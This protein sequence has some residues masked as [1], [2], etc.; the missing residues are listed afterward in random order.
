MNRPEDV[1]FKL[2][3]LNKKMSPYNDMTDKILET[4]LER[5]VSDGLVNEEELETQILEYF[6]NNPEQKENSGIRKDYRDLLIEYYF[7][8]S[9]PEEDIES[10]INLAR[11]HE[12]I[13]VLAR[14]VTRENKSSKEIKKYLDDFCRIPAGDVFLPLNETKEIRVKLIDRFISNQLPYIGIAK[15]HINVRDIGKLTDNFYGATSKTGRIGGKAAGII[16]AHKILKP[17]IGEIDEELEK[18]VTIPQSWFFNSE[19]FSDF[20]DYN[21]LH[22]FHSQKYKN[23][24]DLQRDFKIIDKTIMDSEMPPAQRKMIRGFLEKIG[25]DAP[26][27]LR[28]ST[29]LEDNMGY[30]FS[31]KYDSIFISNQ[32]KIKDRVDEFI[33]AFKKVHIS[34]FALDP[35]IYR[36]DHNLLDFDERMN[37]LVQKVVGEKVGKYFFPSAAGVAFS[38]NGYRWNPK[39]KKEEGLLRLVY[40]LGTRAVDRVGNDYPRMISLS[41]PTLRPEI[42]APQIRKYSQKS[43]DVINLETRALETI[44]FIDLLEQT[45]DNELPSLFNAISVNRDGHLAPPMF[46]SDKFDPSDACITFDN[47]INK[48]PFIRIMKKILTKLEEGYKRPVDVEFAW[49]GDKLYILQCRPLNIKKTSESITVPKNIPANRTL[50]TNRKCITSEIIKNIAKIV[51]VDPKAYNQ[52]ETH[53]DKVEI[54]RA[55]HGINQALAG[56]RFALFGP[57]RWGSSDI[58]LGV[59]VGYNDINKALIL[60]EIAFE[61]G[62]STPEVSFGTHF[63]NDLVEANIISIALF[64]DREDTVFNE[65]FFLKSPNILKDVVP[66]YS[67]LEEVIH[68]ID[69]RVATGGNLLHVYQDDEHQQGIGYFA[70]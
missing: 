40:G 38:Y 65:E 27:I 12:K 9:Y 51:Y 33:W 5:L 35:I 43:V 54:G 59:K 20:I 26:L 36:Q 42:T 62:G 1:L 34:T 66:Q 18:Y 4:F 7:I 41:H 56:E 48:T 29:L 61:Q 6:R 13:K 24:G 64:P 8:S 11:K 39:I 45:G 69:V 21:N 60:G 63:F 46:K 17:S 22:Y 49:H 19:M 3:T 53:Q 23:Q 67:S 14:A 57:G 68:I 31:G 2:F 32:G 58:S 50:F 10:Y 16:L 47:L 70:P 52:L 15:D 28:S 44:P 25:D 30:S 55:V 37:V